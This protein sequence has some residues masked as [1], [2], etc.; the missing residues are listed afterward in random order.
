MLSPFGK[1]QLNIALIQFGEHAFHPALFL[2]RWCGHYRGAAAPRDMRLELV[3]P[4]RWGG[5]TGLLERVSIH[6]YYREYP[7]E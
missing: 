3:R 7:V 2:G 1:I 4:S 5:V 6:K